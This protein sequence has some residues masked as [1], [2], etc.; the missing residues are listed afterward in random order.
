MASRKLRWG[1]VSTADIGMKKVIPG[2]LKSEHS[3]VVAIA[4]RDLARAEAAVATLGLQGS[5]RAHGSYEAIF[6]D[7]QVE[8]VYIPVPN[9]LHI[10]LTLAAARAG[11]HVLCE[12][13]IALD[14][15]EAAQLREIPKGIMFSEAFM[16]RHHPQWIRA[17]EIVQ[18]GALGKLTAIHAVFTY[19]NTDPANVR[20]MAD[21]GG[22]A[23]LDIGCYPIVTS[24]YIFGSEPKRVVALIDR[25]PSFRT[26]RLASVIADFG[27]G[28]QLSFVCGTQTVGRQ[29]VEIMGDAGSLEV[30]IPFN[31]SPDEKS[32]LILNTGAPFDRSLAS[33]EIV[34]A[35]DQYTEQAENFALA[36]LNG[37]PLP[38]GVEDAIQQARILDAIF[39]SART[40]GWVDVSG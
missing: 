26:D 32:A 18:S 34:P 36:V 23:I 10:P 1:I 14:A 27:D 25:D 17:R 3:Q 24:R 19:H 35:C 21:I 15:T 38:W 12:K 31:A 2:I 9:H 28:R 6:A 8:A 7:P 4:S 30:V 11:K 5:A 40:G 33:R 22:G 37:K 29:S 16:V 20:N 13:P 39:A